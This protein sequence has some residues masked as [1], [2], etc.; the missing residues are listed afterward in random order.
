MALDPHPGDPYRPSEPEGLTPDDGLALLL[1][2]P[3]GI[4]FLRDLIFEMC[5]FLLSPSNENPATRDVLIGRQSIGF[6]LAQRLTALDPNW[7]PKLVEM[8]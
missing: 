1:R 4:L 2:T 6:D 7:F 3:E 8:K 5:G